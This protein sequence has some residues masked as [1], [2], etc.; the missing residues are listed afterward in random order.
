MCH[1]RYDAPL[2]PAQGS[3]D[4]AQRLMI[5]FFNL[6]QMEMLSKQEAPH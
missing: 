1:L 4:E 5:L 3:N 6:S 2:Q